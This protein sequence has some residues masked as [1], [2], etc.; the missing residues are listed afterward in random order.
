MNVSDRLQQ[1]LTGVRLSILKEL[2]R[3]TARHAVD[4][5]LVG[6]TVR[7]ILANVA[8]VDVDVMAAGDTARLVESIL[9]EDAAAMKKAT[10]FGT[11]SITIRGI[12]LD[13]ST[14]RRETYDRPGALPAVFPGTVRDDLARRDF[15]INSMAISLAADSW[16]DLL[17]PHGG[18]RD[19]ERGVVRVIHDGSFQD[20]ATRILR[21]IR[22]V[23]RFGFRLESRTRTL[24]KR[25]LPY[26]STISPDRVRREIERI[27]REPRAAAMI[28]MAGTLG[29]LPA[30]HPALRVDPK[31]LQ[32]IDAEPADHARKT[33]LLLGSM[34]QSISASDV[35][36]VVRRLNMNVE[37]TR[38]VRDV[39]AVHERL[40]ELEDESATRSRI[41]RLLRG[42]HPVAVESCARAVVDST[43]AGWLHIY[44]NELRHVRPLLDG[45]D[46][47]ALG[48]PEGPEIGRVLTV[49]LDARL[50]GLVRSADDEAELARRVLRT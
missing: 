7:D 18:V 22:Y 19:L 45:N 46:L 35:E 47:K 6:G 25:G 27:V 24:L 40:A 11:W 43:V 34:V 38:L 23:C 17:D 48:V 36:S 21:A 8:P 4:L 50:D 9:Q 13:L 37:W 28:E 42:I 16:G 41:Y 5:Y 3:L 15:S 2:S 14:A 10:A 49:L 31:T 33:A 26:M 44:L 12:D 29:V 30:I 20:D 1:R 32:A 39:A